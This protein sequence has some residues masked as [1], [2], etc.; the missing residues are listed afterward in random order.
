MIIVHFRGAV[1]PRP[2]PDDDAIVFASDAAAE[3]HLGAD[4]GVPDVDEETRGFESLDV[5]IG[6]GNS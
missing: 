5:E 4:I 2:G 1:A 6:Q 3:N